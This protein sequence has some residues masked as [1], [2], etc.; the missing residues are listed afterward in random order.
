MLLKDV[1]GSG[2]KENWEKMT[3][4]QGLQLTNSGKGGIF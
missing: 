3:K 1:N 4:L 2:W